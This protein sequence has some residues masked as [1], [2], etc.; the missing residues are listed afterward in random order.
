MCGIVGYIGPYQA[1]D[2]LIDGLRRLEYRGY[3]S[4]GVV[5]IN[6]GEFTVTKS[7]GR[8]DKLVE[9][10]KTQ[11]APGNIG[12]R[13]HPLGHARARDRSQRPSAHRVAIAWS[14]SFTTA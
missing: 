7:A 5:T 8:V 11:P 6:D 13:P 1:I 9:K 4:S 10:L 2:Y 14:R 3:D 12:H